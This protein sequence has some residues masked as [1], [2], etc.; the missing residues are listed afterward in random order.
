[1]MSPKPRILKSIYPTILVYGNCIIRG[2]LIPLATV[3]I[4]SEE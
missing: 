1:M 3:T 4:T 2:K